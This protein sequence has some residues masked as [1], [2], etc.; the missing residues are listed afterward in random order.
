MVEI[1]EGDGKEEL[2]RL[3]RVMTCSPVRL[4]IELSIAPC[5]GIKMWNFDARKTVEG[6]A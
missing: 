3:L 2:R 6:S 4:L 1:E 5:K